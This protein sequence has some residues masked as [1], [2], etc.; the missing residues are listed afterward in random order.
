[1]NAPTGHTTSASGWIK[2]SERMP[3]YGDGAGPDMSVLC[4]LLS[5]PPPYFLPSPGPVTVSHYNVQGWVDEGLC[6]HW[7]PIAAPAPQSDDLVTGD[8]K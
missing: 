1:M 5:M 7:M 3:R 6:T 2:C 4:W 8:S